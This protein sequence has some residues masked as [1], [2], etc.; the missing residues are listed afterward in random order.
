MRIALISF[1]LDSVSSLVES[2]KYFVNNAVCRVGSK[3]MFLVV[4]PLKSMMMVIDS[5]L[6]VDYRMEW[7]SINT[8]YSR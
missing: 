6:S 3:A 5:Y 1:D 7:Y 2:Q 4:S 8:I